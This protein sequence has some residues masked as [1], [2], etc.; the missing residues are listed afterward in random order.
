MA[1][2][3]YGFDGSVDERAWALMHQTGS[4]SNHVGSASDWRVTAV[5]GNRSTSIAPGYLIGRGVLTYSDAAITMTHTAPS[6]GRWDLVAAAI[7]WSSNTVTP[8]VLQGGT[9]TA[10][11]PTAVPTS[12]P[13][14]FGSTAGSIVHVPL[15]WVWVNAST[16]SLIIVDVR[17]IRPSYLNQG[18]WG[19]YGGM[20]SGP[21]AA[22]DVYYNIAT[23]NASTAGRNYTQGA[24]WYNTDTQRAERFY[25]VYNASSNPGGSNSP[26]W[27]ADTT[28]DNYSGDESWQGSDT[29]SPVKINRGQYGNVVAYNVQVSIPTWV[30][31]RFD[32]S[33][34]PV[35]SGNVNTAGSVQFSI[36]DSLIGPAKRQHTHGTS[37]N[38]WQWASISQRILLLPGSNWLKVRANVESASGSSL[39]YDDC[40]I[41]VWKE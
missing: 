2:T 29:A 38:V 41:L 6:A 23:N 39:S 21:A 35:T 24:K 40:R 26:G 32:Y 25:G 17:T 16:T 8:V 27:Y 1:L 37:G 33:V 11:T 10:T 30:M 20:P 9:T 19:N 12:F 13:G 28:Y 3:T 31:A 5:S 7:D 4:A 36:N 18:I 22:R 14:G 34:S 15:A